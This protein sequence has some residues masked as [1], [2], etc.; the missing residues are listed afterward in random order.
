MD[1]MLRKANGELRPENRELYFRLHGVKQTLEWVYPSLIKN[2]LKAEDRRIALL[3]HQ[4]YVHGPLHSIIDSLRRVENNEVSTDGMRSS[5]SSQCG[6]VGI[7]RCVRIHPPKSSAC[8]RIVQPNRQFHGTQHRSSS[9]CM[10]NSVRF[11]HHFLDRT[12]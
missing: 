8:F 12:S 3:G 6:I 10:V 1:E 4:H 9:R 7:S 11:L 2:P 5:A